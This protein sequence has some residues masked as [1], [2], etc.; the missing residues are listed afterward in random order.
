MER[1]HPWEGFGWVEIANF[2]I[3]TVI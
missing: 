3:F 2:M 1:V